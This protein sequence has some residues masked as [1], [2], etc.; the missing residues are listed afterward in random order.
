[1]SQSRCQLTL[2]DTTKESGGAKIGVGADRKKS[3]TLENLS[4]HLRGRSGRSKHSIDV[5]SSHEHVGH[6]SSTFGEAQ[7]D[8]LADFP[9]LFFSL[10]IILVLPQDILSE[11]YIRAAPQIC[12]V[13]LFSELLYSRVNLA[14]QYLRGSRINWTPFTFDQPSYGRIMG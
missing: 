4:P 3:N 5:V 13:V 8:V 2:P 6:V 1:M 7:R 14:R 12:T 10:Q 11:S 9:V